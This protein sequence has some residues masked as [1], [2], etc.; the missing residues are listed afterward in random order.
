MSITTEATTVNIRSQE[1]RKLFGFAVS[2]NPEEIYELTG[3]PE[4]SHLPGAAHLFITDRY[5]ELQEGESGAQDLLKYGIADTQTF[6]LNIMQHHPDITFEKAVQIAQHERTINALAII[7]RQSSGVSTALIRHP[8][9]VYDLDPTHTAI[10][11]SETITP[12]YRNGCP[13]VEV[14]A[15]TVEPWPIFA[16]FAPWAGKLALISYFDHK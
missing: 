15:G 12:S 3:R 5:A 1:A 8:G 4:P 11:T 9:D 16:R 7:A 2:Q 10:D 13:A 6:I 14:V